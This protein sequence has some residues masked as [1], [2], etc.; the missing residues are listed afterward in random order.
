MITFCRGN[1]LTADAEAL[2]NTVNT[3]GVMGKGIALQ[4]ARAYPEILPPYEAACRSGALMPGRVQVIEREALLRPRYLINLPTKR[5]WRGKSRLADIEAG[6]RDLVRVVREHGIRSIAIPPLGCGLGGLAWNDV[7][8][9]IEAAFAELPDVEVLLY[10]PDG[11][12]AP[13]AQPNRTA[14][15]ELTPRRARVIEVFA[16]Y[17]ALG[18]ELSLLEVQK[19]LYFL[20]EAGDDL[21]LAYGKDRYGPYADNLRHVLKRFEGHYTIGYGDGNDAPDTRIE[22][23]P[24]AEEHARSFLDALTHMP[25]ADRD[26][27]SRLERVLG[28]IEGFESPYGLELL[29][30][31]HWVATR[32]GATTLDAAVAAVQTWS[33]S[34]R[35]RM[36]HEHIALAWERLEAQGW[37]GPSSAPAEVAAAADAAAGEA[38]APSDPP[39]DRPTDAGADSG[40]RYGHLDRDTLIRLLERRDRERQL[41]LVWERDDIETDR[42]LN[43]DYVALDLDPAL[44]HGE[45][46]WSNLVI[47]GDNFDALRALRMSH[48]GRIRCI[49]IDPPYNTGNRDF[50]YN[51]R[52]VDKT[53]RFRHS[54]WLEFMYRRL[55]LARE[56]LAPDGVI[57]VSI[58]DN[59]LFRLGMLM[60]QVFGPAAH[61]AT[62]VW[63]KRYS[64]ENREAIGDAH[65]YLLVY[66]PDPER[67]KQ[68]RGLLPRGAKQ[69]KLFRNPDGDPRGPWQSV[70]LLAQGY[71]PNQMYAITAPNGRVH[72]PPDGRCWTLVQSEMEKLV[73][74]HRVY[75]GSD[76]DGVPRRK[77]FLDHGGGLVP[78]TWW[79]HEEVGHTDEARKEIR[80]LLGT[81]TAFDTPK[82]V[83]LIERVLRIASRPGDTV[84]DFFA[85]SGTTAHAVA[86]LNAEDGG[87]RRFILVS[88]T[89][90]TVEQ[91]DKN[92]CRDVCAERVRR[93]LGGYTNAK[94]EVV[95]GLGGGFAYLRARRIPAHRL[96]TRID[97]AE[98]WHALCL[99]HDQP[100]DLWDG[101]GLATAVADVEAIVYLPRLDAELE[102]AFRSWHATLGERRLT[103]YSW[104]PER[105]RHWAPQAQCAPIPES[106]RLRFGR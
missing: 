91:P 99:I 52:Y 2:V 5:H 28:L 38:T 89:E 94:G 36:S 1:L 15:P 87:R 90:A 37:L 72:R 30:T 33:T 22:L 70:S 54:L 103:L 49:Y 73:A 75:F 69:L 101:R 93:V 14:S 104:T 53:H 32:E 97:H 27:A 105:A 51:D 12:P 80:E 55:R 43:D 61:V 56:L 46:P 8:S 25:G 85:G 58:D 57:F 7:R 64:R 74:D 17:L 20:Q 6:L 31:V 96:P 81:Q 24:G 84:L 83:R 35:Q 39:G 42:A 82:P 18:Y 106:L 86:R 79:P 48:A 65:E 102:A 21:R 76:G 29:A 59:E 67:F 40:S 66:A 60:D 34:K 23:L 13:A 41:G 19:L 45:G 11:A 26:G 98:V 68:R 63:Q 50:V 92:L 4:F 71:R 47:E 77:D 62:C 78:W 95:P 88:S 16:A 9:R 100:L 3:D 10:P 44:S